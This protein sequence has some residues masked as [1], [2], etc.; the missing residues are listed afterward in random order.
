M[1]QIV[2]GAGLPAEPGAAAP[3]VIAYCN[4]GVAATTVLFALD[5]LG[6]VGA[7]YDGSWNEWGNNPALPTREGDEP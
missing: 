7:N 5:R 4:G 3:P 2:A 6:R 1:R